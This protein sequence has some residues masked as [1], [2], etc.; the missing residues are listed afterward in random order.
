MLFDNCKTTN[1]QGDIGQSRAIY[2]FQLQ[3]YTVCVPCGVNQKYDLVIEKD[4]LFK[5]VQVKTTQCLDKYNRYQVSL[6]ST[7]FRYKDRKV[8]IKTV[9]RRECDYD[10]LFVLTKEGKCYIIPSSE[11]GGNKGIILTNKYDRYMVIE[12][13]RCVAS[14]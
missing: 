14:L 12:D 5:K 7:T 4:G 11:L 2:E 13:K 9:R 8:F 1:E 10:L 6:K 3:G